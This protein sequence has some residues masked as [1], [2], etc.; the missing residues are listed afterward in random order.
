MR[1]SPT[2][3]TDRGDLEIARANVRESLQLSHSIGDELTLSWV[4]SLAA[5]LVLAGGDT[6]TA[7]RLC[8][9]NDVLCKDHG[10]EPDPRLGETTSAVRS[11]LGDRFDEAWAG[12][13][14]LDLASA[15]ELAVQALSG[16]ER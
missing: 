15:V 9:A 14:T 8:A 13:A 4:L 5:A 1:V 2:S 3:H 7:A 11:A 12:G 6:E 16:T 10:F